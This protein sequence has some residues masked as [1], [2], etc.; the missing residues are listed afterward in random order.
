MMKNPLNILQMLLIEFRW[1][2]IV[3]YALYSLE[4]NTMTS[5]F[6]EVSDG[7]GLN[8]RSG[9]SPWHLR[10]PPPPPSAQ[11]MRSHFHA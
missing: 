4:V 1:V 2:P 7:D 6:S 10:S 9:A 3:Y 11:V 8:P 5:I